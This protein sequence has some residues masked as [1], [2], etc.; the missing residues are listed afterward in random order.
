[1]RS[2]KQLHQALYAPIDDLI[3]Y[4]ALPT[5]SIQSID[6]FLFLNHH[7]PQRYAPINRGLPFGPHPHRG[8]ETLTFVLQGD[9]MHRDTGGGKSVIQAGGVQWMTAGRGLIH[10]EESSDAF[11][12]NGG[13]EEVIQIWMNLPARLKM[14]TPEY[15]GLPKEEI[16]ELSLD[17]GKVTVHLISGLWNEVKGPVVS[18]TNLL[19]SQ[20]DLRAGGSLQ[21]EVESVRNLLFYV[22]KGKVK[23]NG[24][25]AETHTLVEFA[26]DGEAIAVEA[27]EDATL[28]FGHG[29][30]FNEPIVAQG[31]FVMNTQTE[32]MQAMRDY[33]M[34]KMG[35]WTE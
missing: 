11:K 35:V 24:Q 2:I 10:A 20:I 27:L 29:Q 17:G 19:M 16:P 3:T 33:Q 32:I 26:N 1:M 34:G 5:R 9:I 13:M 4:R 21:T 18:L 23:V 7:G 6:P 15:K 14:T 25:L 8:F 28:I 12:E 22:V 31:P 30:P